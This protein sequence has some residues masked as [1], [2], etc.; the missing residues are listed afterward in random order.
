[1]YKF[2]AKI[3]YLTNIN[4]GKVRRRRKWGRKKW[5]KKFL[6]RVTGALLVSVI[7]GVRV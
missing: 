5:E 3:Y 6:G 2:L 1:L 7:G 4:L